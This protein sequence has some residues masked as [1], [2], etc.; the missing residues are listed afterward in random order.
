MARTMF[1]GAGSSMSRRGVLKGALVTF[2]GLAGAAVVGCSSA[3]KTA[4]QKAA[5]SSSPAAAAPRKYPDGWKMPIVEGKP[6]LGGTYTVATTNVAVEHDQHTANSQSEWINLGEPLLVCDPVTG[7]AKGNIIE[8]WENPDPLTYIFHVRK[9]VFLHNKPPWNGREFDAEDVVFNLMRNGGKTA[10]AEGIPV[11][12]FQRSGTYDSMKSAEAVDKYTVK[13]TMS[14]PSSAFIIGLGYYKSRVMPKGVLEVGFKDPMKFAGMGAYQM[15]EFLPG[16][17][18]VYSKFDKYY[19]PG[20]PHFDKYTRLAIPDRSAVVAAFITKQL[21]LLG[22]PTEQDLKT[23]VSARPDAL[24]YQYP[25]ILWYHIKFNQK[26][27]L[28]TDYRVR[29]ALQLAPDYEDIGNGYF[30]PGGWAYTYGLTS[31]FPEAWS[32]DYVKTQPGYNPQTKE[33]DRAEAHK[34]LA[35]AGYANGKGVNFDILVPTA[36]SGTDA[37]K[38]NSL[39]TQDQMTKVFP[40]SKVIVR[41]SQD[42]VSFTKAQ[43]KHDFQS[44]TYNKASQ[45]DVASELFDEYHIRGSRNFGQFS[46]PE[47]ESIIDKLLTELNPAARKPL[48]DT[49]QQKYRDEWQPTIQQYVSI[50]KTLVQPNIAG[51]DRLVGPWGNSLTDVRNGTMYNV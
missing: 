1:A 24:V 17:R 5:D 21:S 6:L 34:L 40:D 9:G 7:E 47:A 25:G 11:A 30:G 41:P 4:P 43:T 39:R 49:F 18:E 46:N 13:V 32:P 33:K 38:A 36:Y 3:P 44:L 27:P 42:L 10:K 48:I 2:G 14:A 50:S 19:R 23:I 8:R 15:T 12:L 45:Y 51:F 37:L 35:A 31:T 29:K 28:F 26:F 16:S 22:S 20:E